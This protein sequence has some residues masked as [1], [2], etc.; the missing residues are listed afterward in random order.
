MA[1]TGFELTSHTTVGRA[2]YPL[3]T[4]N[5][6]YQFA[7]LH[8]MVQWETCVFLHYLLG[9]VLAGERGGDR[10]DTSLS[11]PPLLLPSST[12]TD[13]RTHTT[14]RPCSSVLSSVASARCSSHESSRLIFLRPLSPVVHASLIQSPENLRN[15]PAPPHTVY[16]SSTHR[17]PTNT[18]L[19]T[20]L[21][22]AQ[23]PGCPPPTLHFALLH[24]MV[25]CEICVFLHY[26]VG[27]VLAGKRGGRFDTSFSPPPLLPSAPVAA[28]YRLRHF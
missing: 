22:D 24:R 6:Y 15:A 11:P 5:Q 3:N 26:L 1:M 14:R 13:T 25:Q 18:N 9:C 7:F 16:Y 28:V 12:H 17:S 20:F 10:F 23:I 21:P 8:R 19:F 2:G 4:P 27:C